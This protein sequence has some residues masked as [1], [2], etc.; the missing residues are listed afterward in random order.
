MVARVI[1]ELTCTSTSLHKAVS[2]TT[3][4]VR[5]EQSTPARVSKN[6][7]GHTNGKHFR[8]A[9]YKTD[10]PRVWT[11]GPGQGLS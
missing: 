6:G 3:T 2:E 1:L 4:V 9:G 11:C 7:S 8:G 5:V 10:R